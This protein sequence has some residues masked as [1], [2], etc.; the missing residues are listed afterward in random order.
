MTVAAIQR[1]SVQAAMKHQKHVLVSESGFIHDVASSLW[2]QTP[3]VL[4]RVNMMN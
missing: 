2:L 4:D 1:I 3:R